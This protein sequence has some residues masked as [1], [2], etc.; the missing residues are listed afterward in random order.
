MD[1]AKCERAIRPFAVHKKNWLFSDTIAG[2]DANAVYYSFIE[3]AK[4]QKITL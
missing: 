4:F 2:A 3:T 1:K